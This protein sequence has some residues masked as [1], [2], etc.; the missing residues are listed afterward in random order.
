MGSSR[1]SSSTSVARAPIRATFC[2]LPLG[3]HGPVSSVEIEAFEQF[4]A[5]FLVDPAVRGGQDVQALS[6]GQAGPQRDVAGY[7]ASR[8]CSCAASCTDRGR[9]ARRGRRRPASDRAGHGSSSICRRRWGRGTRA[10]PH[11]PPPGR[12]VEGSDRAEGLDHR[13]VRITVIGSVIGG[14]LPVARGRSPGCRRRWLPGP[15]PDASGGEG[16]DAGRRAICCR[17]RT[18][19]RSLTSRNAAR[20]SG[21][22]VG[23]TS[24]RSVMCS[25]RPRV[26]EYQRPKRAAPAGSLANSR[27]RR[28][29]G[30]GE[31]YGNTRANASAIVPGLDSRSATSWSS[32]MKSSSKA[33]AAKASRP[34]GDRPCCRNGA[35]PVPERPLRQPRSPGRS[36]RPGLSRR[37][38]AMRRCGCWLGRSDH[39]H[40]VLNS[41]SAC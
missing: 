33:S 38:A 17:S 20:R 36:P 7:V 2:R 12:P 40:C 13:S 6:P 14:A 25:S 3:S 18:S 35:G 30:S 24:P 41:R 26:A 28:Y 16:V 8:S 32:V 31:P 19:A 23:L 11:R 5:S 29:A 15:A 21:S 10:P 37:T 34:P 27:R 39:R 1:T 9:R 4:G 22:S